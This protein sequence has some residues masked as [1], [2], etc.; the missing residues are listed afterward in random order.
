MPF[1]KFVYMCT[2][3]LVSKPKTMIIGLEAR[4][5]QMQNHK[6]TSMYVLTVVGKAHVGMAL[7]SAAY[8]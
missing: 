2:R 5:V 7:H 1:L 3:S 6:L 8:L 4:L